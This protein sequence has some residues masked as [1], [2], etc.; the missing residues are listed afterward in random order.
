MV[1]IVLLFAGLQVKAV[2]LMS[3]ENKSSNNQSQRLVNQLNELLS[4]GQYMPDFISYFV[5]KCFSSQLAGFRLR[6]N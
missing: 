4:I 6:M 3:I 5:M 2:G 1:K